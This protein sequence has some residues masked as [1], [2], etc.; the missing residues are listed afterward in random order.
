M[1]RQQR[2]QQQAQSFCAEQK[3]DSFEDRRTIDAFMNQPMKKK[4]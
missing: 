1:Q 3:R 2:A 4:T